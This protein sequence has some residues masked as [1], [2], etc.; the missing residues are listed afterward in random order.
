MNDAQ[1]AAIDAARDTAIATIA[2]KTTWAGSLTA[3]A[4]FLTSSGFGVL[5]GAVIGVSGLLIN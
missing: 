3:I 4:G 1:Q 5:I 2:S